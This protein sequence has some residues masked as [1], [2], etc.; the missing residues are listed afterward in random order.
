M[1]GINQGNP[2]SGNLPAE[3]KNHKR[4]E[5]VLPSRHSQGGW[6]IGCGV[7]CPQIPAEWPTSRYPHL[8]GQAEWANDE[9]TGILTASELEWK[10]EERA[11][12]S[13]AQHTIKIRESNGLQGLRGSASVGPV[14][15]GGGVW[16][17]RYSP[18]SLQGLPGIKTRSGLTI[19]KSTVSH[20][21]E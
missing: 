10:K 18:C 12:N 17:G 16:G 14:G 15:G 21:I 19:L 9:S 1:H 4:A 7:H 20:T 5:D 6:W 13:H 11:T 8:A 2:R 3:K